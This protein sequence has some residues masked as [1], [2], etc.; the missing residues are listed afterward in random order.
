M[1]S[2]LVS[3]AV[4]SRLPVVSKVRAGSTHNVELLP[5]RVVPT[6]HRYRVQR[7]PYTY[8]CTHMVYSNSVQEL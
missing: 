3:E 2:R 7:S 8:R 5:G 1:R 6:C 4:V